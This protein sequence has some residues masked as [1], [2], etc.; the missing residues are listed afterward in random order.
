M[1]EKAVTAPQL[2]DTKVNKYNFMFIIFK[3][4][5][6]LFQLCLVG[7]KTRAILLSI[8]AIFVD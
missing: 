7:L 1:L 8:S 5:A 3:L 2:T 4:L 6:N